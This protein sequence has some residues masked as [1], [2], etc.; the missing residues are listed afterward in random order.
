MKYARTYVGSV[1]GRTKGTIKTV[2]PVKVYYYDLKVRRIDF[3]QG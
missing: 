1:A 3:S 2:I